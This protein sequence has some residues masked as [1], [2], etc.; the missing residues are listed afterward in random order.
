MDHDHPIGCTSDD[1]RSSMY[2][3][4]DVYGPSLACMN[5]HDH[6]MWCTSDDQRSS[7]YYPWIRYA[8][9][10]HSSIFDGPI[11]L[12]VQSIC[13]HERS[14][15]PHSS[16]F[17]MHSSIFGPSH[18]PCMYASNPAH[19]LQYACMRGPEDLT[20]AYLIPQQDIWMLITYMYTCTHPCCIRPNALQVKANLLALKVQRTLQQ[21]I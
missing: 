8:F 1:Q 15:G 18:M 4:C 13:M 11:C 17:D 21:H 2:Y 14:R 9:A 6:P 19:V 5:R 3:P 10:S 16:I 12:Q 20:A 7:M